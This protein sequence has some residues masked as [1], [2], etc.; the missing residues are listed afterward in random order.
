MCSRQ[1]RWQAEGRMNPLLSAV[2]TR[3][4]ALKSTSASRR[5]HPTDNRRPNFGFQD[6]KRP[7]VA[8]WSR[9]QP[10]RV[11]VGADWSPFTSYTGR[12]DEQ[13]G[14]GGSA[15]SF[16]ATSAPPS[17][18]SYLLSACLHLFGLST[19][20]CSLLL[21]GTKPRKMMQATQPVRALSSRG[22][23]GNTT[24]L[25]GAHVLRALARTDITNT[26][27]QHHQASSCIS[28]STAMAVAVRSAARSARRGPTSITLPCSSLARTSRRMSFIPTLEHTWWQ[29]GSR[30]RSGN[31]DIPPRPTP[32]TGRL[33]TATR[34]VSV[35]R[36]SSG[37][38]ERGA[39][40]AAIARCTGS[41]MSKRN[42]S[43]TTMSERDFHTVADEAL[44][45][46]HDAVEEALEEGFPEDFDCNMS[47]SVSKK[48]SIHRI[49]PWWMGIREGRRLL[50][51]AFDVHLVVASSRFP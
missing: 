9:M 47:V 42:M 22:R 1:G 30:A 49:C 5:R 24:A 43:S 50:C 36:V 18:I 2:H 12:E 37:R 7:Q 6:E 20:A 35:G 34:S 28:T 39:G 3:E 29:G 33:T 4:G 19:T 51:V 17:H 25:A 15:K 40:A 32:S 48:S 31:L 45:D 8:R 46:I 27:G 10:V 14:T 38:G 26:R 13:T 23:A 11:V 21:C 16:P 44:E 41:D